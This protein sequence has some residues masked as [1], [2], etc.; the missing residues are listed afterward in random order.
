M[1][2]RFFHLMRSPFEIGPDPS[3]YYPTAQ[4]EEA[5]AGLLYG[6]RAGNGHS[7]VSGVPWHVEEEADGGTGSFA[8]VVETNSPAIPVYPESFSSPKEED[9]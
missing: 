9:R 1:Y 8:A 6:I 5:L 4:H 7:T 3:F 2:K